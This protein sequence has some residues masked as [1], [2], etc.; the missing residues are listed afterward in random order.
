MLNQHKKD[1]DD[2]GESG[3]TFRAVLHYCKIWRPRIVLL[4]NVMSAPWDGEIKPHFEKAGYLTAW[5][6]A[7]TK[8][9]YLPQTRQRG[10]MICIDKKNLPSTSQLTRKWAEAMFALERRASSSVSDFLLPDD[11]PRIQR[12]RTAAA[13]H[14]EDVREYPWVNC[15][16]RHSRV[17][18]QLRLGFGRPL[19]RWEAGV[20]CQLPDYADANFIHKQVERV[21]DTLDCSLLRKA[22]PSLSKGQPPHDGYDSQYKT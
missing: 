12:S 21:W 19:T 3:D 13:G 17:R 14:F 1:I 11:D 8:D 7:D 9:Y 5:V 4:E 20:A 15:Q 10:Y 22:L 18:Q 6:E 16:A 2:N